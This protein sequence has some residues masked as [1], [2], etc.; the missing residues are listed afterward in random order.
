MKPERFFWVKVFSCVLSQPRAWR[1]VFL[2]ISLRCEIIETKEAAFFRQLQ[3]RQ[4]FIATYEACARS[5]VQTIFE[6]AALKESHET[7]RT[8]SLARSELAELWVK[9]TYD[10]QDEDDMEKSAFEFVDS[11]MK[12]YERM[13]SDGDLFMKIHAMELKFG[14]KSCW[15]HMSTLEAVVMKCKK[16]SEMLWVLA[17]IEDLLL[18]GEASNTQFSSRSLK[19]ART[20]G[21]SRGLMD[22]W[23]AKRS[24]LDWVLADAGTH[25]LPSDMCL[26][27]QKIFASHA[28]V[29]AKFLGDEIL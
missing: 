29:R 18:R 23:L 27:L 17:T 9:K 2:S 19:G 21:G 24:I 12:V 26:S 22:E 13:L 7:L 15:R 11:A 16:K 25:G 14:K 1:T 8:S 4:R 5:T 10:L 6:I 28:D 3:L 20:G